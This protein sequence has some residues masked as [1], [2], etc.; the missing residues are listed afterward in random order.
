MP[1]MSVVGC[2]EIETPFLDPAMSEMIGSGFLEFGLTACVE[3]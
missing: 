1:K 3:P 2:W